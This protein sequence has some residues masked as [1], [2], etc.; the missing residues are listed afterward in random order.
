MYLR[1][2]KDRGLRRQ[3]AHT[4]THRRALWHLADEGSEQFVSL[5]FPPHPHL[6]YDLAHQ[7]LLSLSSP[8]SSSFVLSFV[9]GPKSVLEVPRDLVV[10]IAAA[11]EINLN[12]VYARRHQHTHTHTCITIQCTVETLLLKHRQQHTERDF[13]G[14]PAPIWVPLLTLPF[15]H[16]LLSLLPA[17]FT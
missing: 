1:S 11:H 15:S 7:F 2:R 12:R 3:R 10:E 17:P 4:H 16:L 6:I 13:S 9:G 14:P 5:S 8:E